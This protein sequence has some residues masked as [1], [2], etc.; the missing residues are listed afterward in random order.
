MHILEKWI[1]QKHKH[2][3]GLIIELR[4]IDQLVIQHSRFKKHCQSQ[5]EII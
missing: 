5:G 3:N 4:M 1:I 2:F